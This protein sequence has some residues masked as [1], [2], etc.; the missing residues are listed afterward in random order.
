MW[1]NPLQLARYGWIMINNNLL[2]CAYC[3]A[4][5]STELPLPTNKAV[6]KLTDYCFSQS[7]IKSSV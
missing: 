4:Y 5:A 7:H 2:K 1:L 3:N 6:C